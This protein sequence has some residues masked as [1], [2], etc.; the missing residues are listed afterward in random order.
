MNNSNPLIPQG[1][2][3]EQKNKGRAR[4][5]IAVF[6]V[7]AVHGIGLLALLMQG[8]KKE[9][10]VAG[11]SAADQS[12]SNAV[13]AF[14]EPTNNA[15]ADTNSAPAGIV[16]AA[17]AEP[18]A[19]GTP[20]ASISEYKITQGDTFS[21]IAKKFHTTTR[22]IVD[23]NPGVEP[24]KLR[25]GQS[26]HIPAATAPAAAAGAASALADNGSSEMY[27]VKS[28]DTLSR[29]A[30]DHKVSVHSLRSVNNL[31]TDRIKVGQ[32]LKIPVKSSAP[33][34][35]SAPPVAPTEPSSLT[36]ATSSPSATPAH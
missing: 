26:I 21:T 24:T 5:K 18:T 10:E 19:P 15:L 33:A 32:K 28:G 14:V 16:P 8:C 29:I 1:S 12:G 27:T 20:S 34:V 30:T 31:A 7:L 36:A 11:P 13:P 6:V 4:V 2:F 35:T 22:A 3:L 23:A 17:I 25:I 9:P